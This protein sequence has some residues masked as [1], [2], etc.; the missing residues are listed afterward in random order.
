MFEDDKNGDVMPKDPMQQAAIIVLFVVI[1]G[2]VLFLFIS[3]LQQIQGP[4]EAPIITKSDKMKQ[5]IEMC[6]MQCVR[7][8]NG[9]H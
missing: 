1:C 9:G 2:M 5:Q 3:A 7:C 8:H 6:R 4:H